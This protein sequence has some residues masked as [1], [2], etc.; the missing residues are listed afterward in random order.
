MKSRS[1]ITNEE[2][3]LYPIFL[4]QERV[5]IPTVGCEAVYSP[6]ACM[7]VHEPTGELISDATLIEFDWAVAVWHTVFVTRSREE[8]EYLGEKMLP[9]YKGYRKGIDWMVYCIPCAGNL[10]ELLRQQDEE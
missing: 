5:V 2:N 6:D 9:K 7:Y 4:V 8:G 10:V 3:T 1:Y